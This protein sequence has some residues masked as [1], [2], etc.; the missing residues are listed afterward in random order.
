MRF[1]NT[2]GWNVAAAVVIAL[3]GAAIIAAMLA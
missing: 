2:T 3:V 1:R